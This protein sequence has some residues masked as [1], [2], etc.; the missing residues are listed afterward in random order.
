MYMYYVLYVYCILYTYDAAEEEDSL[1]FGCS[2][3]SD[4]K[5][6]R[7]RECKRTVYV[8]VVYNLPMTIQ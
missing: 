4:N 2:C 7:H 6:S 3:C 8:E 1:E 5:T